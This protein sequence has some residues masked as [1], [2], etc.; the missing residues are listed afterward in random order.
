MREQMGGMVNLVPTSLCSSKSHF[1]SWSLQSDS[2]SRRLIVTPKH[3]GNSWKPLSLGVLYLQTSHG[4]CGSSGTRCASIIQC[5]IEKKKYPASYP[6]G[7][8]FHGW[9]SPSTC[10]ISFDSR[11]MALVSTPGQNHGKKKFFAMIYRRPGGSGGRVLVS[12]AMRW[13]WWKSRGL[14]PFRAGWV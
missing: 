11:Y 7:R 14:W 2:S 6:G 5:A 9:E 8:V 12:R 10:S 1:F 13:V 4:S 3:W